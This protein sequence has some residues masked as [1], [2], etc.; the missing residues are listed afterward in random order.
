MKCILLLIFSCWGSCHCGISE[1]FIHLKHAILSLVSHKKSFTPLWGR[2]MCI[3]FL[4]QLM[5]TLPKSPEMWYSYSYTPTYGDIFV[6]TPKCPHI[7]TSPHC[8]GVCSS[9]I[10]KYPQVRFLVHNNIS[11]VKYQPLT[12]RNAAKGKVGSESGSVVVVRGVCTC[13]LPV[14]PY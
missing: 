3:F 9:F 11:Y 10:S 7:L 12:K 1:R 2:N 5:G 13:S 6:G 14:L 4:Y 8:S